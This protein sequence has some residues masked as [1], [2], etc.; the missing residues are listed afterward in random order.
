MMEKS[1]FAGCR[2]VIETS[3]MLP[4]LLQTTR[5]PVIRANPVLVC[6]QLACLWRLM[7]LI[8][9]LKHASA[10]VYVDALVR[11]AVFK[12]RLP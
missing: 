7:T 4:D 1:S 9:E 6:V 10:S 11:C 5:A 2:C 3:K 12:L 8:Y